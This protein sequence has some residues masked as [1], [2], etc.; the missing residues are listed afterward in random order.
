MSCSCCSGQFCLPGPHGNPCQDPRD[1][2]SAGRLSHTGHTFFSWAELL[3]AFPGASVCTGTC[4][5]YSQW[6]NWW[7]DVCLHATVRIL[8]KEEE[9]QKFILFPTHHTYTQAIVGLYYI[10]HEWMSEQ[11][12]E[13]PKGSFFIL[14]FVYKRKKLYYLVHS[15]SCMS[16]LRQEHLGF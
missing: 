9:F 13:A 4:H 12:H 2:T 5:K 3:S 7:F 16:M 1:V 8:D 11:L 14:F 10:F 15:Y 6:F